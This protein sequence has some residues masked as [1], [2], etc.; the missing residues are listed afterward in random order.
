M[1][2]IIAIA[3][4]CLSLCACEKKDSTKDIMALYDGEIY[5][6]V[7]IDVHSTPGAEYVIS[8]KRD[9]VNDTVEI[10]SPSSVKG[11]KAQIHRDSAIISYEGKYLQ[12]LLPSYWGTSPADVM[13]AVFDCLADMNPQRVVYDDKIMAEDESIHDNNVNRAILVYDNINT[14]TLQYDDET[15]ELCELGSCSEKPRILAT[16][17]S[18]ISRKIGREYIGL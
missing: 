16:I 6:T 7:R 1:K 8:F 5:C 4:I 14:T 10:I 13:S 9:E 2:R 12:T 15:I 18:L 11:I 17:K 3:F